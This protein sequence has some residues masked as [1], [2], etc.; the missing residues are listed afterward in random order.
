MVAIAF[1]VNADSKTISFS[2]FISKETI[3]S[4]SNL[5]IIK[6]PSKTLMVFYWFAMVFNQSIIFSLYIYHPLSTDPKSE[7]QLTRCYREVGHWWRIVRWLDLVRR[8]GIYRVM[9]DYNNQIFYLLLTHSDRCLTKTTITEY[10]R[11]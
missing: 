8:S 1:R 2:P 5:R 11:A 6:K 7:W 3:S 4:L 9:M 10:D